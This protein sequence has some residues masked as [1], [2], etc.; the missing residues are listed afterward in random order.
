MSDVPISC[1]PFFHFSDS[2]CLAAAS[3]SAAASTRDDDDGTRRYGALAGGG[4]AVRMDRG[5]EEGHMAWGTRVR[6][7]RG[8]N[9]TLE[10]S[11]EHVVAETRGKSTNKMQEGRLA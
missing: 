1:V 7:R 9:D 6:W 8:A 3:A 10:S 11:S 4:R 2:V 5:R